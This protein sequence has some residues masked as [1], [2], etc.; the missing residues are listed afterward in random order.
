ME[1]EWVRREALDHYAACRG[2]GRLGVHDLISVLLA[3][4]RVMAERMDANG[5]VLLSGDIVKAS[6]KY[7]GKHW[8]LED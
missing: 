7:L 2:I 4:I 1:E 6:E 5:V 8:Y 3:D